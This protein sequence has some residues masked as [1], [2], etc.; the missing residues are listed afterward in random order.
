MCVCVVFNEWYGQAF[1]QIAHASLWES[2]TK[3]SSER[4]YAGLF[5]PACA[6][7]HARPADEM[8]ADMQLRV[9]TKSR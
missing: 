1:E 6:C 9:S 4:T 7:E 8:R 2:G 3:P 5:V